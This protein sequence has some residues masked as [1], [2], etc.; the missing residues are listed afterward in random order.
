MFGLIVLLKDVGVK[1]IVRI[2]KYFILILYKPDIYKIWNQCEN[3]CKNCE[4]HQLPY[5]EMEQRWNYKKKN[6]LIVREETIQY[7]KNIK[8]KR[9]GNGW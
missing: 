7:T 3:V 2:G 5:M 6:N 4:F 9:E 8:Q 1:F